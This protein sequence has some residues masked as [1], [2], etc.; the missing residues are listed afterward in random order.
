[1]Q[2]AGGGRV[3]AHRHEHAGARGALWACNRA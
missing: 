2:R 3:Q 1:V